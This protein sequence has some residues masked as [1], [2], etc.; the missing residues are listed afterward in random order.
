MSNQLDEYFVLREGATQEEQ[1]SWDDIA[2]RCRSGEFTADT[3]LFLPD[4]S[5]WVS[6]AET[7]LGEALAAAMGED[8]DD[9]EAVDEELLREYEDAVAR[10]DGDEG[11]GRVE[12]WIDAGCLASELGRGDEARAHFQKA[13]DLHPFHPRVAAEV[14]RRF[15]RAEWRRFRMLERPEAPWENLGDVVTY[16]FE[17]DAL[18]LSI[19]A[20]VFGALS[21]VPG[22]GIV[23]AEL[24]LLWCYRCMRSV[25]AGGNV[26]VGWGE[27]L[28]D[29][30][31][32]IVLPGVTT[33]AVLGEWLCVFWVFARA[34]MWIEGK[35]DAGV[36]GYIASSPVLM[37]AIT[38]CALLYLPAV[39]VTFDP[40]LRGVLRTLSPWSVVR[41]ALC[42]RGEYAMTLVLLFAVAI[43]FGVFGFVTSWIPY[44]GKLVWAGSAF[45][46]ALACAFVLGRLR[47]RVAHVTG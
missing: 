41:D 32:N 36:L 42:M 38:L 22:G 15:P 27:A 4:E 30:V 10:L 1:W 31:R 18:Y 2:E 29:P 35:G 14:H 26:P 19:P 45:V 21:F 28:V 44:A 37:I 3:R 43:V 12:P 24:A 34:G 25:A 11:A 5:R 13:L 7:D 40:T 8:P 47:A 23:I 17:C 16:P 20:A 39:M 33:A 6:V 46:V 9:G